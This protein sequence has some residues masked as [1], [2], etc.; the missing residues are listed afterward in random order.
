MNQNNFADN[1]TVE[2]DKPTQKEKEGKE[3]TTKIQ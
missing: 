2:D 1:F 3:P